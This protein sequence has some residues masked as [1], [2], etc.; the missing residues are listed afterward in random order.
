MTTTAADKRNITNE[1]ILLHARLR[2]GARITVNGSMQ[3]E[4]SWVAPSPRMVLDGCDMVMRLGLESN[5]NSPFEIIIDGYAITILE[6][7]EA[8]ATAQLEPK[9]AW[10][11][12]RLADG[13]P[14]GDVIMCT[15]DVQS[16]IIISRGC[17]AAAQGKAC[18]FCE[19]GPMFESDMPLASAEETLAA[20]EPAIEATIIAINSGWR[21]FLNLAGGAT[22]PEHR[23]QWTT[24]MVDAVMARFYNDVDADIL[25]ELQIA[26][27]VYPPDDPTE[28]EKWKRFGVNSAEFDSQ[29]MDPAY[30][31]AI[32]PGRGDQKKWHEAQ[33]AAAEI[34]GRGR[35]SVANVVTGI[36]PMA[37]LLEGIEERVSKGVWIHPLPFYPARGSAMAGMQP[38]SME[39]YLELWEKIAD[40]YMQYGDTF[41]VDPAEDDRWGYTRRAQSIFFTPFKNVWI[42]RLQEAGKLPPGLP[43]QYGVDPD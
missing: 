18:R 28:M 26:V 9:A 35:G 22:P 8:V 5:E 16:N 12:K 29:I 20:A 39:W 17:H 23:G 11:D 38:A 2:G 13:R 42:R 10:R 14:V 27:Q 41:D 7:G 40:I 1:D 33:E 25:A 19:F 43:N 6:N 36:E 32:C 24:D 4:P 21:G 30:F 31:A 34:F 3:W 15:D 37:G